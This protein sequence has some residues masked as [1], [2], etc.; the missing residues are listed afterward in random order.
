MDFNTILYGAFEENGLGSPTAEQA[1]LFYKF[2]ERLLQVNEKFN[3]TAIRDIPG[4]IYKHLCDSAFA[5]KYI[6]ENARLIDVGCGAG[7]PSIPCAILRDDIKIVSL[8][9]TAKKVDFI[10]GTAEYLGLGNVSAL[11]GRAEELC[12][13]GK[14]LRESFDAATAR[15]VASLPVLTELCMPFVKKGGV[16]IAM[17]SGKE[18][19]DE[20]GEAI[21]RMGGELVCV[22]E[23][24][25]STPEEQ[26]SRKLA[27]I[28]KTG[29]TPEKYPRRYSVITKAPL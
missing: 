6:P 21:R 23:K 17:R 16:F 3:L 14:A 5:V 8:D 29:C 9:S 13:P 7:F 18:S 1:E 27:L 11:C 10:N 25:L 22:D 2:T 19:I 26:M 28:K 20:A 12:V 24:P 4:V 15:A